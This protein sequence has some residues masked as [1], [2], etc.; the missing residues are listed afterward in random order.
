MRVAKKILWGRGG[1]LRRLG[2]PEARIC[3]ED[4]GLRVALDEVSDPLARK[5]AC[6]MNRYFRRHPAYRP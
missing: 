5:A 6:R 4:T 1:R 2:E 3:Y